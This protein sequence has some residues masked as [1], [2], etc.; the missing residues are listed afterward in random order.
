MDTFVSV[1]LTVDE[2]EQLA[3]W[4]E[5]QPLSADLHALYERLDGVES[6]EG[7]LVEF[8][9]D[10]YDGVINWLE[11]QPISSGLGALYDKMREAC[12]Q[13]TEFPTVNTD[14]E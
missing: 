11:T 1:E 2:I 4:L 7:G 8:T 12:D 13:V 6:G 5:E 10:D 14:E 3:E 9:E